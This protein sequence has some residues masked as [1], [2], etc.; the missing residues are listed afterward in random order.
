MSAGERYKNGRPSDIVRHFG[1]ETKAICGRIDPGYVGTDKDDVT[2][3]KCLKKLT[4]ST[5]N[6]D[7]K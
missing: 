7:S 5:K 6:E 1:S 2:C 3:K 4:R